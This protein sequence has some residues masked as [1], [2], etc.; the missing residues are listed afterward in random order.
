MNAAVESD[1]YDYTLQVSYVKDMGGKVKKTSC[2]CITCPL[3]ATYYCQ[4]LTLHELVPTHGVLAGSRQLHGGR[5]F[6]KV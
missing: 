3:N 2:H 4:H 1:I 5:H 6:P